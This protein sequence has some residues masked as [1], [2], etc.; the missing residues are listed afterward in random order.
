MITE[1][2]TGTCV[3]SKDLKAWLARPRFTPYRYDPAAVQLTP[4][5]RFFHMIHQMAVAAAMCYPDRCCLI[6]TVEEAAASER[7]ALVWE[8]PFAQKATER[9]HSKR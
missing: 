4:N 1:T 5:T 7:E 9:W 3:P 8:P 6:P 2:P